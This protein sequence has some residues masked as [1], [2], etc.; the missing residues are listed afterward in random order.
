M[1]KLKDKSYNDE[2]E[3]TKVIYKCNFNELL[4][5]IKENSEEYIYINAP[6]NKFKTYIIE[7]TNC[8]MLCDIN[9]YEYVK[10]G[11]E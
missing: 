4:D 7:Y 5:Y 1:I 8:I 11:E 6:L 10:G 9:V 2:F 3:T